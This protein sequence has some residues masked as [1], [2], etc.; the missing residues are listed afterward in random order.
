[1][2]RMRVN[3]LYGIT[4]AH[5]TF[6]ILL[7]EHWRCLFCLT[8]GGKM[9]SFQWYFTYWKFLV[10]PLFEE[11]RDKWN[12]PDTHCNAPRIVFIILLLFY[13]SHI[14]QL[15]KAVQKQMKSCLVCVCACVCVSERKLSW[16][17]R[18]KEPK[19]GMNVSSSVCS[20][21]SR[22]LSLSHLE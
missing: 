19:N 17:E 2:W 10:N 3:S 7:V 21:S 5:D 20:F 16:Q 9:R 15:I 4:I 13:V 22:S 14:R 12:R 1:M 8:K 11:D 18:Q 6:T